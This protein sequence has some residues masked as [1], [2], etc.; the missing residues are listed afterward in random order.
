LDPSKTICCEIVSRRN[1]SA[2]HVEN[3]SR[4][5]TQ[6]Q[7]APTPRAG[8]TRSYDVKYIL[9]IYDNANTRETFLGE[10]GE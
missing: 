6:V 8:T 7:E 3:S 4:T 10:E 1:E 5:P 2:R 9:L